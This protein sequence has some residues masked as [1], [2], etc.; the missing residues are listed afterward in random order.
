M[1]TDPELRDM[2]ISH[3]N[4]MALKLG[5]DRKKA[6][7]AS[8]IHLVKDIR[9]VVWKTNINGFVKYIL[10]RYKHELAS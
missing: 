6:K 3:F 5:M 4:S 10:I 8:E 7:K 9:S 2:D 1:Q